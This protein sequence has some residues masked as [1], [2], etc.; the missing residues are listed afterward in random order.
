MPLYRLALLSV[1]VALGC[2]SEEAKKSDSDTAPQSAVE[3]SPARPRIVIIGN[4]I[5][6][7]YGL[8]PEHAF[9][10]L[11]QKR[12]DSLGLGYDVVNAGLSGET[13]SGG[14]R[15]VGWL[16]RQPADVLV[17]ELGGNDG[18]RGIDPALTK[19]N[20]R[21]IISTARERNPDIR[22]ILGGMRMPMNMGE[23]YRDEFERVFAE[24]ADADRVVLIPHI[25]EGVGGVTA[26]NQPDGIHPTAEGQL[27]I[28]NNVWD[29][30]EPILRSLK[31]AEQPA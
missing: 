12:I 29:Y 2:S 28:A 16:L 20:L 27:V 13:T 11:L 30:L 4:S 21:T 23:K 15:R 26:L 9:P 7:G 25:L 5:T 8:A 19:E 3:S 10:A 1:L 17:I 14:V 31:S 24:V 18:L 6:A 22:V